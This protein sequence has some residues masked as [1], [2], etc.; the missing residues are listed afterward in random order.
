MGIGPDS[1]VVHAEK[2]RKAPDHR[3]NHQMPEV[4]DDLGKSEGSRVIVVTRVAYKD[5]NALHLYIRVLYPR[6]GTGTPCI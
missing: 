6:E 5:V 4:I 3:D 1:N 2:N